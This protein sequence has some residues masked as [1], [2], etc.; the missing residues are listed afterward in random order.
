MEDIGD[1]KDLLKSLNDQIKLVNLLLNRTSTADIDLTNLLPKNSTELE[2]LMS[3]KLD[4]LREI[5][6]ILIHLKD[7]DDLSKSILDAIK[8]DPYG[9]CAD[10]N[11]DNKVERKANKIISLPSEITE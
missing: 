1:K 6:D 8:E 11:K 5:K 10:I 4:T 2:K 7:K 9:L 3:I